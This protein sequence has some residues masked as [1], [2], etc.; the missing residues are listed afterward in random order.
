MIPEFPG[1]PSAVMRDRDHSRDTEL[2][3][4]AAVSGPFDP[5]L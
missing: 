4:G 1:L 5:D 3:P 2:V